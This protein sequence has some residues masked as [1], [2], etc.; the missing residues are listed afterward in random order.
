MMERKAGGGG[1]GQ[2]AVPT[3][4][5]RPGRPGL[6]IDDVGKGGAATEERRDTLKLGTGGG[7]PAAG[8]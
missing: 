8:E 7:G 5:G 4:P 6:R 2:P 1:G 3:R